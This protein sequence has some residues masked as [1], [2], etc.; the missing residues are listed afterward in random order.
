[1][2]KIKITHNHCVNLHNIVGANIIICKYFTIVIIF[3][4]R[5]GNMY[6]IFSIQILQPIITKINVIYYKIY[7]YSIFINPCYL[8]IIKLLCKTQL[9]QVKI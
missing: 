4:S 2:L 3:I 7:N 6:I 8:N 5:L 9:L 1:M